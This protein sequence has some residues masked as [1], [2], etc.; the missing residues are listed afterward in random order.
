MIGASNVTSQV[1]ELLNVRVAQRLKTN[2]STA[3]RLVIKLHSVQEETPEESGPDVVLDLR[4]ESRER[5]Y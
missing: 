1:I 2:A 5:T 4:E 3:M